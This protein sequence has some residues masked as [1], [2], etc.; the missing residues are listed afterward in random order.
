MGQKASGAFYC[1]QRI[2]WKKDGPASRAAGALGYTFRAPSMVATYPF[3][4]GRWTVP[5][6]FILVNLVLILYFLFN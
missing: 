2:S 3:Y 5:A 1:P 6:A 4:V